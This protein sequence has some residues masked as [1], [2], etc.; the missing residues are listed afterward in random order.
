V[1]PLLEVEALEIILNATVAVLLLLYAMVEV[2][3]E[4]LVPASFLMEKNVPFRNYVQSD[5]GEQNYHW[6]RIIL[7]HWRVSQHS[8]VPRRV[9]Q[10]WKDRRWRWK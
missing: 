10:N 3:L 2:A 6:G 8:G 7:L 4:A 9:R 5:G 1:V